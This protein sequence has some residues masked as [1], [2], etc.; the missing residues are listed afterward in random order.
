MTIVATID[1]RGAHGMTRDQGSR[2][3]CLA[4]TLSDLTGYRLARPASLSPEF[5]YRDVA[6]KTPGW[7]PGGGLNIHL[8]L[9]AAALPGQ[10]LEEECPYEPFEPSTP[11]TA[12][13]PY[14]SMFTAAYNL[15]PPNMA[16]IAL[17]LSLGQSL[18]LITYVTP[19]LYLVDPAT[20]QVA[21]SPSV[22]PGMSHALVAVGIGAHSQTG[23]LHVLVRNS[24]GSAWGDN[25]HAWL[26]ER[27]VMSHG[28]YT[29][30]D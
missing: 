18:G 15:R 23:E 22:M 16:H 8:A 4:F 21:F 11:L 25:G 24:W 27:Y 14:A 19:E 2:P 20:A 17:T 1:L 30:G 26:P 13:A 6:G 29:F 28:I 3:T 12:N 9:Q 10:P 7:R 5:L